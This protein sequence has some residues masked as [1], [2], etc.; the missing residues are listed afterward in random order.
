MW[1]HRDSLNNLLPE[2]TR[3][4]LFNA[5]L[6]QSWV[7]VNHDSSLIEN[8]QTLPRDFCPSLSIHVDVSVRAKNVQDPDGN[9]CHVGYERGKNQ[10]GL[11]LI[12]F[13]TTG[14]R[15]PNG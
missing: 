15:F 3:S 6:S 5:R 9:A 10:G 2:Q 12:G 13:R 8:Q 4:Q 1:L 14:P 7:G 11:T